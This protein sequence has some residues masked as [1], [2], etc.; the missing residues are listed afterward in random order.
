M[1]WKEA[2]ALNANWLNDSR[3][4]AYARARALAML[5][6]KG[7]SLY[8]LWFAGDTEDA[9][10]FEVDEFA[11]TAQD[12]LVPPQGVNGQYSFI[13]TDTTVK[14]VYA[15]KELSCGQRFGSPSSLESGLLV[16]SLMFHENDAGISQA[17][18]YLLQNQESV[19][20]ITHFVYTADCG[21][22]VII[23][24]YM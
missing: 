18:V 12:T 24:Q 17:Q 19:I 21:V 7:T 6:Q 14:Q 11:F 1:P 23:Y 13:T 3:A 15:E 9:P 2:K 8:F 20:L 4:N 5:N 22:N 16:S 10:L